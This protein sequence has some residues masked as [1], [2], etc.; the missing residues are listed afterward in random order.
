MGC[1]DEFVGDADALLDI[2]IVAIAAPKPI[3]DLS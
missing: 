3:L 2:K 1:R